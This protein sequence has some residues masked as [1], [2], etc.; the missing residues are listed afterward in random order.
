MFNYLRYM[1]IVNIILYCVNSAEKKTSFC[2]T[3]NKTDQL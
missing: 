1:R 2:L 3:E